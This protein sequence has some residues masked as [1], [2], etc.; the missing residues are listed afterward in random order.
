MITN[1]RVEK[2]DYEA[3]LNK[4]DINSNELKILLEAR[5]KGKIKFNLVDT[6]EYMEWLSQRI[7]GTD[8][9]IPTMSFHQEVRQ[10]MEQKDIPVVVYCRSGN[11]SVYCQNVMLDLGFKS[12]ANL[13]YG[14]ISYDGACESGEG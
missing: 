4:K 9:L 3:L 8:F 5:S 13:D 6:R 14:I 11:R 1:F 10:I 2:N 7:E 12:V